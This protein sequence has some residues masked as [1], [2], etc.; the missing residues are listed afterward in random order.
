MSPVD[1]LAVQ[2]RI[3]EHRVAY[4]VKRYSKYYSERDAY[5]REIKKALQLGLSKLPKEKKTYKV[6][7]RRQG[8]MNE[9]KERG[10]EASID[11]DVL[12]KV[13]ITPFS[14]RKEPVGGFD[15]SIYAP[16]SPDHYEV[17][18]E[19]DDTTWQTSFPLAYLSQKDYLAQAQKKLKTDLG[20]PDEVVADLSPEELVANLGE[21]KE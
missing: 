1:K 17:S 18:P 12:K 20:I 16:P 19:P 8:E 14:K 5:Y 15:T 10:L 2:R 13:K 3:F 9:W 11:D 21:D 4:E 7:K 6:S